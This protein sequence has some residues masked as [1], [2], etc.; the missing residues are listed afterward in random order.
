MEEA[1]FQA[2][3]VKVRVELPIFSRITEDERLLVPLG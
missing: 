3:P 1:S 2:N